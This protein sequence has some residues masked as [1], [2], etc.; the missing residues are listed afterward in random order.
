M[1]NPN[2]TPYVQYTQNLCRTFRKIKFR[3][4]PRTPFELDDALSTI[5]S[6][7][8]HTDTNYIDPLDIELKEHL[9]HYS[10]VEAKQMVFHG[11]FI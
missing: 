7:I 8:K 2:I 3:Y 6:M 1:N 11:I 5:A 10:Y 9:S 4:F